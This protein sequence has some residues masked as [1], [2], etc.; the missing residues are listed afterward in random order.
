M[1]LGRFEPCSP[2]V[3]EVEAALSSD[4]IIILELDWRLP[5]TSQGD[6]YQ[7]LIS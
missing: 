7:I 6:Y 2:I 5:S 3:T 4:G 1:V